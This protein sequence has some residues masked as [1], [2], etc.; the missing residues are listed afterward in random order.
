MCS[1]VFKQSNTFKVPL[2]FK[3][4]IEV[5][6]FLW[7][8]FVAGCAQVVRPTGG[9][10]DREAPAILKVS[11][12][13]K[14]LYFN[15]K[16][17]AI[18][19]DEYFIVKDPS[20][21]WLISPPFK[22][23]PEYKIKGKNLIIQIEDTLKENTTYNFNFGKSIADVN[24]GNIIPPW[25]YVFSTGNFI[26][27]LQVQGLVRNALSNQ[28]EKEITIMLYKEARCTN[29]SFAYKIPPDYFSL[30]DDQGKYQIN[31]I[32]EG[33]YRAIALKDLNNNY[34]FDNFEEAIGFSDST[35]DLKSN[36]ELDFK[37][38]KEV[39]SK[40]YVKGKSNP[41]YGHFNIILNKALPNIEIKA[42]HPIKNNAWSIISKSKT[43]DTLNI[44]LQDFTP[45]SIH[46]AL[47]SQGKGID[48]IA[49]AV[50]PKEKFI[51]KTKRVIPQKTILKITPAQG[52]DKDF[53]IPVTLQSNNPVLKTQKDSIYLFEGKNKI[54]FTLQQS[55]SVG[56]VFEVNTHWNS[57]STY[58]LQVFPGAFKDCFSYTN[59]SLSTSFKV[60]LTETVGNIFIHIKPDSAQKPIDFIK[61]NLL[62]QL[63]NEKGLV[64]HSQS[65]TNYG[66]F[67]YSNYKPGKYFATIIVDSNNNNNWDT[68]NLIKGKQAE[69]IIF[70]DGNLNLR[71]NW[72]LEEDWLLSP[73]DIRP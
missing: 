12:E 27:S 16:T 21:Q 31:F 61:T 70:K 41:S 63:T 51:S 62:L 23:V 5:F 38:F 14:S 60:P 58:N 22:K 19:F 66:V 25:S 47:L 57:D 73:K 20:K 11:P 40:S 65:I 52:N 68:G 36:I 6:I 64:L 59:D 55:D 35:I 1:F 10:T 4:R 69:K 42:L 43:N 8:L 53:N 2:R 3:N 44:W 26:D 71:A 28:N 54:N 30:S 34:L 32:K 9:H 72:D 46:V 39:E 48:T 33:K 24:E 45:D 17:I 49:F 67:S 29:D 7:S 50:L 37:I 13:N 15:S 56:L 18:Q